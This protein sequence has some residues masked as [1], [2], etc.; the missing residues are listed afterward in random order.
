M[1][2][3]SNGQPKIEKGI[4]VPPRAK[5]LHTGRAALLRSLNIGDSVLLEGERNNIVMGAQ[6]ALGVGNYACRKVD[7]GFRV[8]RIK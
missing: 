8:W 5:R 7:G 6:Y 2:K 3:K 4:P 1:T